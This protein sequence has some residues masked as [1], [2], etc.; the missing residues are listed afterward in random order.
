MAAAKRKNVA[1]SGQSIPEWKI[2]QP[3]MKPI[4]VNG[5][6]KDYQ[7]LLWEAQ[8][9][10]HYEISDKQLA[11]SFVK[12]AEKTFG[13]KDAAPLRTLPDW[14]FNPIGK[15][16]YIMMKGVGLEQQHLDSIEEKYKKLLSEAKKI[17]NDKI[18]VQEKQ[19]K[20]KRL[21]VVS[22]Q[23]RMLEQVIPVCDEIDSAIYSVTSG[24]N[25]IKQFDPHNILLKSGVV[26]AAHAKM[27]KD[28]YQK[29]YEEAQAVVEWKDEQ[30]KEGYGHMTAKMRRD[31]LEIYE[32]LNSACDALI[33]TGKANRKPRK[34]KAPSKDKLVARLKYKESEPNIGVASVNP[35]SLIG[36]STVWIF[37]TKNRKLGVYVADRLQKSLSVK[38]S[39]IVGFD[40]TKSTQKT[41]RKTDIL[42]GSDKLPR[43][44]IQ[45]LYDEIKTTETAMNGRINEHIILLRV[46]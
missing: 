16:T 38:G 46:F 35:L 11:D 20:I 2:V 14:H 45:K 24:Q 39:C 42:R 18:Q 26:K 5:Q 17:E 15:F 21:P 10:V 34:K 37:N 3:D 19:A 29:E 9:F 41:V 36:A 4:L 13:K 22:I 12:Y 30:I 6:M 44:K 33:N 32:K 28:L 31:F 1:S 27:I 43:T 7:R 25:T 8:Y 40:P 23:Q